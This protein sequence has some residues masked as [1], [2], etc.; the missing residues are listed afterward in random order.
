MDVPVRSLQQIAGILK[1]PRFR[2]VQR[3]REIDPSIQ[4]VRSGYPDPKRHVVARFERANSDL[5]FGAANP[6]AFNDEDAKQA[7]LLA[8]LDK[9]VAGDFDHIILAN[10]IIY[11]TIR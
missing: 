5:S 2:R 4:G 8:R 6:Q 1:C 9:Q 10:R 7:A 11:L 3:N